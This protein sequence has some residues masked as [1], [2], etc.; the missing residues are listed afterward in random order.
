MKVLLTGGAGFI[1]SHVSEAYRRAGFEVVI[2]DNLQ[3]GSMQFVP[4][5]A[6]FY[7][8]DIG[9]RELEKVFQIEKPDIVNHHAAQISVVASSRDPVNDAET[10]CLG[11]LN[12]LQH[13]ANNGVKKFIYVSTGGAIYGKSDIVPT[14]EDCPPCPLSPYGIH[15]LLGEYYLNYYRRQYGITY[16]I[17]R[18]ANVYGPR[19]NFE[20][21]AGVVSIF[22]NNLMHNQ[23]VT[24]YAIGDDD[25]GMTRDYVYVVDVAQANLQASQKLINTNGCSSGG[26]IINIGTSIPTKT[27]E[28]YRHILAHFSGVP[29]PHREKARRGEIEYSCLDIQKAKR[30]L[31]W[32]PDHSLIEGIASTVGYFKSKIV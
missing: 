28:L 27:Y 19:Q 21:E 1:G 11:L 6:R 30:V 2:V 23:P 16:T 22:I 12:V 25:S 29:S 18:Y 15:K 4:K 17:L 24:I 31:G 3:S 26:E 13:A 7:L 14:P 5:D 32:T 8:M 9:S 20:G 10:N